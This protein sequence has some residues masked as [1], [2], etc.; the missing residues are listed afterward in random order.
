MGEG[1]SKE[2]KMLNRSTYLTAIVC[3]SAYGALAQ[4][5]V[6]ATYTY[7][8]LPVPVFNDGADV[9]SI[10]GITVPRALKMTKVTVQLQ[11]QYPNTG[12]LRVELFA[13]DGTR[14][15]LLE[16]DCSVA[17]IDTTFDD[18]AQV[19]WEDFCPVEPGRGP[20]RANQ[21][22]ANFND[23]D[24]S[25]GVWELHIENDSSDSRTGL[26]TGFSLTITGT[27]QETPVTS[28]NTIVNAAGFGNPGAIAPGELFS[29]FGF[30]IG[31]TPAA[32]PSAGAL[33]TTLGGTTVTINGTAI[34]IAY[35]GLFRVDAVAPFNLSPGST[36]LL[37]VQ[38]RN[39][40]SPSVSLVVVNSS[41][42]L[43]T[44][45]NG[46]IGRVQAINQDG[47][48]NSSARPAARGSIITVYAS[49]LGAVSP[50]VPAGSVPPN[51][52]LSTVTAP[53]AATIGGQLATV[54]FAGLAPGIPG[55]YQ[56]NLQVPETA[57][58]GPQELVIYVNGQSSQRGATIE[59]R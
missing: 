54:Q 52:P 28:A 44:F 38:S 19:E 41:P 22:L 9:I 25:F 32:V 8:G 56:V 30:A 13:P 37:E 49:G 47:T 39:Q 20:F 29:I 27:S 7:S 2:K 57:T 3:L 5:S 59:V 14:A 50:A 43:F 26:I 15:I 6:T 31:P 33:P 17:N 48:I 1:P 42:G 18:A 11:V 35:A 51:T 46:G 24:S 36:A 16:H 23:A 45:G 53:V 55:Y 10:A 12:D 4:Q 21:P 34:P 40:T 58:S